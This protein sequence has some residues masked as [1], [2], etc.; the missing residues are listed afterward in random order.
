[1]ERARGDLYVITGPVFELCSRR[2]GAN[3]VQVPNHLFK[4]V[5]DREAELAWDG[6]M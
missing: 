2:I 1:M 3:G 5:Y 6:N 4:L